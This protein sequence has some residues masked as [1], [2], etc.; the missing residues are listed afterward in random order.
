MAVRRAADRLLE[1]VGV[2]VVS[3]AEQQATESRY[4]SVVA[5]LRAAHGSRFTPPL[6]ETPGQL[7]LLC[8][9]GGTEVGEALHLLHLLQRT[10]DGP[11]DVCELGVAQGATSALIANE[12]RDG[13]R[14]LWLY[15]SFQ[16][17][18]A[19]TP[20]DRLIDDVFDL[21]TMD[22]YAGTMAYSVANVLARLRSV[23]FPEGR[24]R[25]VPGFIR[26]DLPAHQLPELVAF[27]YLDFDL[28]EPILTGLRLLHPRCRPGSVLMVDDYGYFSSGP[29]TAVKEFLV[30]HAEQYAL[31]EAP[32]GAGHFCAL[33][34]L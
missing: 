15:D 32:P 2:R 7:E 5:Q 31:L 9:L 23:R 27:A 6:V 33:R 16:G 19:P 22:R 18:S 24:T 28:Y 30:D 3:A 29:E 21:G 4:R 14:Q 13:V 26:P 12:I 11:G 17:L 34:R 10:L 1:P 20:E 8:R 25:V